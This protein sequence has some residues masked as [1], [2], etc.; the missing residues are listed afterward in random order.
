MDSQRRVVASKSVKCAYYGLQR[1][2]GADEVEAAQGRLCL[3][4][5]RK[6][7]SGHAVSCGIVPIRF[8]KKARF[9]EIRR[10]LHI[11]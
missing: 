11:P 8:I 6:R 5:V 10:P 1:L 2:A 3:G 7:R 9:R 4:A